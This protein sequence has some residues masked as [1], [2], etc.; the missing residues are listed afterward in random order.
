LRIYYCCRRD[1]F[2]ERCRWGNSRAMSI[3]STDVL[4]FTL[5]K[6]ASFVTPD[7]G[8]KNPL[9]SSTRLPG[10]EAKRQR[11]RSYTALNP[12]T[13]YDKHQWE[14]LQSMNVSECRSEHRPDD[15][16]LPPQLNIACPSPSTNG[17]RWFHE[18]RLSVPKGK[19]SHGGEIIRVETPHP[20]VPELR[21]CFR[22][23]VSRSASASHGGAG[24]R[25]VGSAS[26]TLSRI[27]LY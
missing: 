3:S 10:W 14:A 8:V 7:P 9:K 24:D 16:P 26:F 21:F 22:F 18:T 17:R 5:L 20:E 6:K 25:T 23:A 15:L 11:R 19:F 12:L 2:L 4:L 27:I 1:R 13:K